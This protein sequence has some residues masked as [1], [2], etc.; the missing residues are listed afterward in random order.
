VPVFAATAPKPDA[1]NHAPIATR[2]S[3]SYGKLPISFEVNQGQTARVVQ[4][5]A[6]GAGYTLFLAPGEMVLSPHVSP[7]PAANRHGTAFRSE[8]MP[9]A[10]AGAGK[11]DVVRMQLIG[12]NEQAQVLGLDPL[13]GKSNYFIGSDPA[14]WHTNISTYAKVRYHDVYPGIDLV[15][16][17]NQEGKLEHDFMVAP[18]A[19][20]MQ[21]S[22]GLGDGHGMA[23][24]HEG[25]LRLSTEAGDLDLMRPVAYQTIDGPKKIIPADYEIRFDN[26]IRFRLARFTCS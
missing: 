14:M 25:G 6:R 18:G 22:F 11:P 12:S 10:W 17:G 21:I 19:D 2:I 23:V 5:L 15:Y 7:P 9:P 8:T 24:E 20:P 4:Y 3:S 16:Y 26:R 13:P 1:E